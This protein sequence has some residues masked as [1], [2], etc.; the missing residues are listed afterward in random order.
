LKKGVGVSSVTN[1]E[2][3]GLLVHLEDGT[4]ISATHVI[5]ADG[6]W[7][8][9]RQSFPSSFLNTMVTC[10]SSAVHMTMNYVP[11]IW[12]P[13]G[14]YMIKPTNDECKFYIIVSPLPDNCGLSISMIYYDETLDKYPWLAPPID[15]KPTKNYRG[16]DWID[17]DSDPVMEGMMNN[18]DSSTKLANH[19]M[20]LF[21]KELPALYAVLDGDVYNNAVV[22]RRVTWLQ[23]E[24]EEGKEV[25]YSTG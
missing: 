14:M 9:V 19:L 3:L 13:N 21:E 4:N 22:K 12:K 2:E 1:D 25:T 5:G 10:P 11:K 15:T 23:M 16:E 18:T 17:D 24:A 7:S 6:K 20:Q 8:N